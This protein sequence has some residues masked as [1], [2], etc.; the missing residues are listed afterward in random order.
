MIREI[1][2]VRDSP[3]HHSNRC[4][5]TVL[6]CCS[7]FCSVAPLA[8]CVSKAALAR[9]CELFL[10]NAYARPKETKVGANRP[11]I[12][13]AAPDPEQPKSRRE[14]QAEKDAV[15]SSRRAIKKSARRH[16]KDELLS[17]LQEDDQ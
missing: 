14:R 4:R 10:V 9:H 16:L 15:T 2:T 1:V 6:A 11:K 3:E 7:H 17:E 12:Q 13:H 8:R 5:I